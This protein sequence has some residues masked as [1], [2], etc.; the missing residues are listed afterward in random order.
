[1]DG[2]SIDCE[3]GGR[4]HAGR[5]SDALINKYP[6]HGAVGKRVQVR[7]LALTYKQSILA[8][9]VKEELRWVSVG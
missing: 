7:L 6:Q 5:L 8:R 4:I 2:A 3:V 1:M 9:V